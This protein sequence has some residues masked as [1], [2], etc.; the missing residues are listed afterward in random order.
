LQQISPVQSLFC[1]HDCGH[2]V[3]PHNPPQQCG[4]V[5]PQS[6]DIAHVR[7]QAV[8]PTSVGF[9]HKPPFAAAVRLGSSAPIVV[10]QVSPAVVLHCPSLVQLF[11]Q[12]L[13]G[14]QM[15]CS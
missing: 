13:A 1:W 4:A 5:A 12:S 9:R 2:G 7:G 15:P 3:V 6:L 10:Q 14:T 8:A 11:G